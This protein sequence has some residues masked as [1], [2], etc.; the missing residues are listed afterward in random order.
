MCNLSSKNIPYIQLHVKILLCINLLEH[1][2][3]K[4]ATNKAK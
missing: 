3:P 1:M 2:L 4:H